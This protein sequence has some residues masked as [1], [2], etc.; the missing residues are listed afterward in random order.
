VARFEPGT[1][2]AREANVVEREPRRQRRHGAFPMA[3]GALPLG[4]AAR[5]EITGAR[6]AR[7]VLAEP[8]AVVDEMVLGHRPFRSEVDVTA[9]AVAQRPLVAVLMASEAARHPRQDGFG[10]LLGHLDVA[11]N[12]VA[13]GGLH[14]L[15][16][17][18]AKVTACKLDGLADVRFSVAHLA[19]AR[20]VW[21]F[22]APDARAVGGH[23]QGGA[24]GFALYTPVALDAVDS[25]ERVRAVL[26]RTLGWLAADAQHAR[27]PGRQQGEG[28][29]P[30]EHAAKAH[31]TSTA[32]DRRTSA[33]V[34]YR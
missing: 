33:L 32:R 30:E 18:E 20:V 1:V 28:K 12:A 13:L 4:V 10:P 11:S 25:L 2:Q 22:V 21:L 19:G 16:V 8:V 26:E 34:S 6:G 5:A 15:R 31:W 17:G 29:E 24:G 14:V 27:A 7:A 3:R 23:V 9:V